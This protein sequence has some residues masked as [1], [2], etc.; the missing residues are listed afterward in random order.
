VKVTWQPQ[1]GTDVFLYGVYVKI[2]GAWTMALVPAAGPNS[3]PATPPAG[4]NIE[5]I[6]VSAID[7]MGNESAKVP[8]SF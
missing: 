5:Q 8:V 3:Y 6:N 7:R 4:G 2:N 1:T